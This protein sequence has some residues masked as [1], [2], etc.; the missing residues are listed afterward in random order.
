MTKQ[1]SLGV[2]HLEHMG[3]R[4]DYLYRISVKGLIRDA[5]GNVLVVKETGRN[6]WD[7]PG[8]GMDHGEGIKTALA[9]EL[10]EEVNLT[11]PF[12][13]RIVAIDEPAHL[14]S[15]DF[16]Q[17]QLIFA[18]DPTNMEFSPGDDGD[19]V[20]FIDPEQLKNSP[21]EVE[22]RVYRYA[23]ADSKSA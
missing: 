6:S 21:I 15:H 3:R 9:R 4:T 1:D 18:V 12:D 2:V 10:K 5:V 20:Q 23:T 22:R 11:G 13:F 19:A 8:G 16:W 17:V 7:L 14:A